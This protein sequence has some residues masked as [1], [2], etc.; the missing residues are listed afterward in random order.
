MLSETHMHPEDRED[1][2]DRL[3]GSLQVI[4]RPAAYEALAL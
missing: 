1:Q 3:V 2:C 4:S